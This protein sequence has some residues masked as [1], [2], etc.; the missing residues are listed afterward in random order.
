MELELTAF[1][2][3]QLPCGSGKA[4]SLRGQAFVTENALCAFQNSH[5]PP[6]PYP[7]T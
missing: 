3:P 5:F 2:F 7:K 4:A 6:A 1:S